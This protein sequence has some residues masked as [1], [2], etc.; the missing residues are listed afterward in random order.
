LIP[1]RQTSNFKKIAR[2]PDTGKHN[3]FQSDFLQQRG[4][5]DYFSIFPHFFSL[6]F[7]LS[8]YSCLIKDMRSDFF[9]YLYIHLSISTHIVPDDWNM[10]Q[11]LRKSF[12]LTWIFFI[13]IVNRNSL[14]NY[15]DI[16]THSYVYIL[17]IKYTY[18]Y[19]RLRF[20]MYW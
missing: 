9:L 4:V 11:R 19:M 20:L 2:L 12:P 5:K 14:V 7:L 1:V 3:F 13:F 10:S 6:F 15:V 16:H 8:L 17:P 18:S